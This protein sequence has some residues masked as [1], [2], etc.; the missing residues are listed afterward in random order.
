[1]PEAT[2]IK[3]YDVH[4]YRDSRAEYFIAEIPEIP[5]CTAD[6]KT[7]AEALSYL[8]ETFAVL[9]ESYAEEKMAF[10]RPTPALPISVRELSTL[11]PII[12]ISRLAEIAG[13][14]GQ[15]LA[16]KLKR[17]TELNLV[18]SKK[19][20]RALGGYGIS[21]AQNFGSKASSKEQ[22]PE[23]PERIFAVGEPKSEGTG[24]NPSGND[25]RRGLKGG[26]KR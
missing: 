23:P 10:P 15:T 4:V 19:I 13:I 17:G 6:G 2:T 18:E 9:K 3:D 8:G 14:P 5:T 21:L 11:A 22:Y 25:K 24:T 20:V 1:M 26:N 7:Q 12:K 16:T